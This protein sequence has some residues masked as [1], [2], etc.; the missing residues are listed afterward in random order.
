MLDS[1][2]SLTSAPN[3]TVSGR[4]SIK[5]TYS[6]SNS[7]TGFLLTDPTYIQF[8][9]NQKYTIRVS[10]RIITAGSAGFSF[11][12]FSGKVGGNGPFV[13]TGSINGSAGSSGTESLTATLFN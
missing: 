6:G 9:P 4:N 8:A 3:E 7:F 13:N 5:G 1:A 10:Y 2:G 11:G 12:F